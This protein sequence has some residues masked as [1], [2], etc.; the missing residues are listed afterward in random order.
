MSAWFVFTALGFYPVDPVSCNYIIGSPLVDKA[1]ITLDP[2]HY[3]GG[4]FTVSTENNSAENLYIQSA[5]LNGKPFNTFWITHDQI[6]HG[7]ELHL[8]M[9]KK[10]S[11]WGQ[12]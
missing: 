2:K 3:P 9:G 4:T 11:K 7:G 1:T 8:L 6:A 10:P 12:P 5:T